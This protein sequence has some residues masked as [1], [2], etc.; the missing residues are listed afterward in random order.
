MMMMMSLSDAGWK[1]RHELIWV[2]NNHVLGRCDYNYK[3]EPIL[4]GW[5]QDGTHK[6]F[7][8]FQTS[9]LEF[10]KPQKSDQHPTT[11]PVDLIGRL[12]ENSTEPD[13]LILDTF[14]G[15]GTTMVAA[16]Q[17]H[18]RC[19]GLEIDPK[20]CQVIIDRMHKLD[21]SL[22]ITINGKPYNPTE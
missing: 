10:D 20:Y 11:K 15:S 8:G 19:Y 4:Y 5:K 17:L 16:H 18:R 13:N 22:P 14:L 1:V 2:K 9:V 7:G 3:H 21:P 6:F 12:I